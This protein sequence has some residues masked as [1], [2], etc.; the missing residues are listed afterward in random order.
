MIFEYKALCLHQDNSGA[1]LEGSNPGSP[2]CEHITC[3]S[4]S[5]KWRE[6]PV[7]PRTGVKSE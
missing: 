4:L 1:S 2:V 6:W 5:L 7:P 3:V